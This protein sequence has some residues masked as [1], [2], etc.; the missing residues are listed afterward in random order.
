MDHPQLAFGEDGN[1]VSVWV[2]TF[3]GQAEPD[4]N[5]AARQEDRAWPRL[6]R[7]VF[8][9]MMLKETRSTTTLTSS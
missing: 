5:A 8:S 4:R 1:V 2:G 7:P 9:E 6:L 3:H